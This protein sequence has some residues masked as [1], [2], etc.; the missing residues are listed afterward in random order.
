MVLP[1]PTPAPSPMRKPALLPSG[2]KWLCC[3]EAYT[4]LSSCSADSFLSLITS[5]GSESSY[6]VVRKT[7]F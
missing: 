1:L 3:C 4:M 5:S 6:L 7:K 2:R